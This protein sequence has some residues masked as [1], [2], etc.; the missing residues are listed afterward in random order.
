MPPAG[1]L[2]PLQE[3]LFEEKVLVAPDLPVSVLG[4]L[5]AGP[6]GHDA[7]HLLLAEPGFSGPLGVALDESQGL[8]GLGFLCGHG[9][10]TSPGD[11]VN[12]D[13]GRG[14][15]G[16]LRCAQASGRCDETTREHTCV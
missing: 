9:R 3:P 6:F 14:G 4:G 12:R 11:D 10:V 8:E 7:G 13:G 15:T 5:A 2:V 1:V 16:A